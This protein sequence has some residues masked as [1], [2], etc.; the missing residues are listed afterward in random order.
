MYALGIHFACNSQIVLELPE[1]H[2]VLQS[3]G[4]FDRSLDVGDVLVGNINGDCSSLVELMV[5]GIRDSTVVSS[6]VPVSMPRPLEAT[7]V[8]MDTQL[9]GSV[10][11]PKSSRKLED[12]ECIGGMVRAARAVASLPGNLVVGGQVRKLLDSFL[13]EFPHVIEDCFHAIGSD[14]ANAGPKSQDVDAFWIRLGKHLG[15]EDWG[16]T[17]GECTSSDLSWVV[18]GMSQSGAGSR[19]GCS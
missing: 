13:V 5:L 17:F 14:S 7:C 15:T 2:G 3:P 12:K 8:D 10:A 11:N 16:P 4:V 9:R 18:V 19:E 6:G 1:L